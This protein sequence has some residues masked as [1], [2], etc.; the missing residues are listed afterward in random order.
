MTLKEKLDIAIERGYTYNPETGE[1]FGIKGKLIKTRHTNG[2]IFPA[3]YIDGKQ[4]RFLGHIFAWY[5]TY[6]ELPPDKIDHNDTI[7]DN[8]RINNLRIVTHQENM[9]NRNAKGY[10]WDKDRQKWRAQIRIN[11]KDI[12]LGLFEKDNED[13]AHQAYLDAKLK[14]HIIDT[15]EKKIII[16]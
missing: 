3:I 13:V 8:N 2:Y 10:Y 11:G 14:Y 15:Y 7:A 1:I 12:H 4:Y 5:Y 9:F 6:D 16:I